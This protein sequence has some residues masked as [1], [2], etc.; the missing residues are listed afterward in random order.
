MS[1]EIL[2]SQWHYY[3]ACNIRA[4]CKRALILQAIM[5]L[6]EN[7]VWS[8][9]TITKQLHID[10][11]IVVNGCIVVFI[12]LSIQVMKHM[13]ISLPLQVQHLASRAI[14]EINDQIIITVF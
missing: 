14:K 13:I 3:T 10:P 9:D 6:H 11:V 4:L 8:S 5:P 7:R 2:F 12:V 1:G